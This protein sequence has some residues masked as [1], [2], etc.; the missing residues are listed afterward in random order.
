VSDPSD[1][2]ELYK[3]QTFRSNQLIQSMKYNHTPI[4]FEPVIRVDGKNFRHYT[5]P[6]GEKLPS[7]T[8]ILG[9]T[10]PL[11]SQQSIESWKKREGDAA[12]HITELSKIYGTK[13][14]EAIEDTLHNHIPLLT[15]EMVA[16]HYNNLFKYLKKINNIVGIELILY[17][18]SL[19]I[20]GTADCI[21]EYDGVLSI[22]D[23]KTKRKPQREEWL[24]DPFIQATAYSIMFE[25]LTGITIPQIVV[26]VSSENGDT[27]EF[28]K[29]PNNYKEKLYT[30]IKLYN[31]IIQFN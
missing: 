10:K 1:P 16:F 5:T 2:S 3:Q 7:I 15:S 28:V 20:A 24:E 18:K 29:D 31:E 12:Y 4:P 6:T 19:G 11:E 17:S 13:T 23:Y 21:A 25:E 30:R 9:K 26:L 8:T 22:L 14:H 27:Q